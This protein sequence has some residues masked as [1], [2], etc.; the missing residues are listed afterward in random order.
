MLH[1]STFQQKVFAYQ[2]FCPFD[3]LYSL[4]LFIFLKSPT[5][6]LTVTE[7]LPPFVIVISSRRLGSKR[8][9]SKPFISKKVCGKTTTNISLRR[10]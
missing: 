5:V 10:S 3:L 7:Q 9:F 2:N 4:H 6:D 8:L 1:F